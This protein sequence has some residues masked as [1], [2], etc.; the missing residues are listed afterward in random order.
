MVSSI[1]VKM[2]NVNKG[3]TEMGN[4]AEGGPGKRERR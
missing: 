2:K 1:N 3:G 4:A